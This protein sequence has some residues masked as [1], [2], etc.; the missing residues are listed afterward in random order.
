MRWLAALMLLGA[1][2]LGGCTGAVSTP[3]TDGGSLPDGSLPD[4][5][6]ASVPSAPRSVVAAA[7]VGGATASWSAPSSSGGSPITGYTVSV[8]P[9]AAS[10]HVAVSGLTATV[11]GLSPGRTVAILVS[12]VNAIG[13]GPSAASAPVTP[14]DV[15]GAPTGV[16]AQP[17]DGSAA[18]SWSAPA[19]DG[20]RPITRYEVQ[21]SPA[22]PGGTVAVLATVAVFTGLSNGTAYTFRV[23]AANAV[24]TGPASAPS[25]AVTPSQAV[26]PP[27]GLTYASNPASYTVSVAIAPNV[28]RTGG[29]APSGFSASSPLPAGLLLS[30]T[31]GVIT[32]T[33]SAA[34][35]GTY[36]ITASNTAGS[37]SVDLAI[38]VSATVV[39]GVPSAP[40]GVGALP[41][42]GGARV[43]WSAPASDGG[44]PITGYTLTVLPVTPSAVVTVDGLSATVSGL[45]N[46]KTVTFAVSA[47]NAVG[48][49]PAATSAPI[50]TPDVPGAPTGVTAQPGNT[51]A[52]VGWSAP[53]SDGGLP[54][55]GYQVQISP[56]APGGTVQVTGT[57]AAVSGLS[58]GTAYTFRV[59]AVNAVGTGPASAPSAPVTPTAPPPSGLTYASNPASYT[60]GVAITPNTPSSSGG[61]ASSY[62]VSPALP[63]GLTLNTTTGV[64][65]GTPTAAGTG[66]YRVTASNAG[67]STSVDLA[68]TVSA[69]GDEVF[70]LAISASRNGLV[71]ASGRPFLIQGDAAWSAIAQLSEADALQYLDD[72]Q[73]RG[74]NALL[75]NLVEHRFTSHAP[76]QA[77]AAGQKPFTTPSDMS[78]TND[79]YFQHVDWFL[80]QARQRGM[81][82]LLAPAYLGYKGS[83]DGWIAEMKSTG[84]A[85]LQTYGQYLGA[86]YKDV[87]NILWVQG[88]DYTPSSSELPLLQAIVD[89]LKGAGDAHLHTAHWGGEPSFSGPQP[90]WIDV[91]TVYVNSPPHNYPFMV[92]GWQVDAGKRPVFFIEGWYEN[93]HQATP[94]QL[95]SDMYQPLVTGEA[96]F[97][98]GIFPIWSFWTGA[99]GNDYDNDGKYPSWQAALG[100][101]GAGDAQ[102]ARTLFESLDWSHLIPDVGNTFLTGGY[103]SWDSSSY[104]LA[105]R[106]ADGHLGVAYFT[107]LRTVTFDLTRMAG[108]T[109]ASWFDPSNGTSSAVP[110]SPFAATGSR[111]FTPPGATADGSTD[112]VL[113]LQSP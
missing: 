81:L 62:A 67:G 37:T 36:R 83:T 16:T 8:T 30:A 47:V 44:A 11:T 3:E 89:G 25:A 4:G 70:P 12:A 101:P 65:T 60:V 88:G 72:R 52:S 28:P 86:R 17:G 91:D 42:V 22:V 76:P 26:S 50:T 35:T 59:S 100:S 87:P 106:T 75:V 31:S 73:R 21:I 5:G 49:G 94:L 90:A 80:E 54:I 56:A 103:G 107:D 102:R 98:F 48:T 105:A 84:T 6:G 92:Q 97:V 55:S 74:F 29:G 2:G 99:P 18:V 112:W 79:A 71:D 20:G 51:S 14:P 68:I 24:G 110:G 41:T 108:T 38:T 33:P 69:A 43:G 113:L 111:S 34:G 9:S 32:G 82:V 64:I 77:N 53:S 85:K 45:G 95:R 40:L 61:A 39:P 93:E 46:G 1:M 19:S 109:R 7:T 78:T 57:T 96:G 10:A 27:S 13:A 66:T 23:S 63:A 58:N 104:V 15:P